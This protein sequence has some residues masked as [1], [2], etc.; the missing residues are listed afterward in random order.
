MSLDVAFYGFLAADADCRTSQA[1][2][3]WVRLR[4]GTGKDEEVQWL[5]V[6]VFG[7]AAKAAA[8]LKKRDRIYC[9]GT[10]KLDTWT[11]QDGAERHGLSVS[12]FRLE[13]THRI[14]RARPQREQ[15]Q[16]Q[17]DDGPPPAN[18]PPPYESIPF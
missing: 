18:E 14:G 2:K 8:E 13:Q 1:G 12:T 11:G 3:P 15:Q 10:L 16:Q 4:V 9:E 17:H 5:N 6:A 7:E